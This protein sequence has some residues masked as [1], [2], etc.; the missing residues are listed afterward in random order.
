MS[1]P[2]QSVSFHRIVQETGLLLTLPIGAARW[3]HN[4]HPRSMQRA[5]KL[6]WLLQSH[7]S[8][9]S[10]TSQPLC[11]SHGIMQTSSMS[12]AN[13][14]LSSAN[15]TT[16]SS[17]C[18][19]RILRL[20]STCVTKSPPPKIKS[21]SHPWVPA[22]IELKLAGPWSTRHGV[23]SWQGIPVPCCSQNSPCQDTPCLDL[24]LEQPSSNYSEVIKHI[25][26]PSL[27]FF[28]LIKSIY[29]CLANTNT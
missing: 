13:P 16:S 28:E 14:T 1:C 2:R 19:V 21:R 6:W 27:W 11:P 17:Q 20:S 9:A 26:P 23:P 5:Q 18:S 4:S 10:C 3:G 22:G 8:R 7:H 29:L 15:P 25:S 12:S 24:L